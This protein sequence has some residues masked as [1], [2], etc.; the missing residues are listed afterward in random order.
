MSILKDLIRVV[1]YLAL[2]VFFYFFGAEQS[3]SHQWP[4]WIAMIFFGVT[5]VILFYRILS[6]SWKLLFGGKDD[7]I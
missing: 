5:S 7:L 1:A 6:N 3:P 4:S 2:T